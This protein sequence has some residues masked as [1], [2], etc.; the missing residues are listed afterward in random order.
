MIMC[1]LFFSLKEIL[2]LCSIATPCNVS[3]PAV[4]TWNVKT[5][6]AVGRALLLLQWLGRGEQRIQGD[7][8]WIRSPF[9][10]SRDSTTLSGINTSASPIT[11]D[12][13]HLYIINFITSH[14]VYNC[15]ICRSGSYWPLCWLVCTASWE[16]TQ[17]PHQPHQPHQP[18]HPDSHNKMRVLL[19]PGTNHTSHHG[20]HIG[21]IPALYACV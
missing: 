7:P 15:L 18:R 5:L 2:L 4:L 6:K 10:P 1:N 12:N 20:G 14:C 17:S 13:Y 9:S 11:T 3:P 19:L 16:A 21:T 8:V